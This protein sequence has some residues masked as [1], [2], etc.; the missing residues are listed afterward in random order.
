MLEEVRERH[1]YGVPQ[2]AVVSGILD[3][4]SVE[5]AAGC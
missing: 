5:I 3:I 1:N 2:T 4:F